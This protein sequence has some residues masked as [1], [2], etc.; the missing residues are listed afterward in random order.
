MPIG[1]GV[2]VRRNI[3]KRVWSGDKTS[4]ALSHVDG[5][6]RRVCKH[7]TVSPSFLVGRERRCYWRCLPHGSPHCPNDGHRLDSLP[8]FVA[9]VWRVTIISI[10]VSKCGVDCHLLHY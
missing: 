1:S 3:S 10:R 4:R 6:C 7:W 9:T 8:F 2:C 5:L